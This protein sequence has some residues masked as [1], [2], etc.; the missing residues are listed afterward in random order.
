MKKFVKICLI[1]IFLLGTF[2]T[3]FCGTYIGLNYLKF[4]SIPLKTEALSSTPLT[5]NVYDSQNRLMN[6][7]TALQTDY[8]KLA[9]LPNYTQEAFLAIEDKNFYNHHGLNYKRMVGAMIKNIKTMSLKEGAST[10]S[11]QLI[12]NTHLNSEKTFERKL[13]EMALTKKLEKA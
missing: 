4:Q 7:Q 12:K 2:V 13:K 5:V 10:I 9:E 1:S 11:Q 8:C 6:E 3:I